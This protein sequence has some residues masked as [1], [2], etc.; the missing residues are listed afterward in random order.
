MQR[1]ETLSPY[2]FAADLWPDVYFADYQ[3]AI[4]DS[5][6]SNYRTTVPAGNNGAS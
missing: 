1:Y 4:I 5:V 2:A 6:V 3:R